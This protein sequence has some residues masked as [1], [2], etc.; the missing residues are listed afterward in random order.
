MNQVMAAKLAESALRDLEEDAQT[1][2]TD[3]QTLIDEAQTL[4]ER[5]EEV[6]CERNSFKELVITIQSENDSIKARFAKLLD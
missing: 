3:V 6:V 2:L 4:N 5:L 1:K